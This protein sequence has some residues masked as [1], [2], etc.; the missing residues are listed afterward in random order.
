MGKRKGQLSASLDVLQ[1]H[2][3]IE[4]LIGTKPGDHICVLYQHSPIEQ[5]GPVSSFFQEGLDRGERCIYIAD[6]LSV[7]DVEALLAD[8]GIDVALHRQSTSLL[9]WSREKWRQ[10]G[11]LDTIRKAAQ[12][13][14]IVETALNSGFTG[15]RFAV[16]MTWTLR[17]DIAPAAIER[18]ES[19]SDKLFDPAAPVQAMCLYGRT[20]LPQETVEGGLRTHRLVLDGSVLRKN[21][22]FSL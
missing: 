3:I 11:V 8:A 21:E 1:H 14:E 6:D 9:I 17:P 19:D 5:M 18:W 4:N 10:P 20:R 2:E 22:R 13:R 7:P 12:V 16:E 15:V